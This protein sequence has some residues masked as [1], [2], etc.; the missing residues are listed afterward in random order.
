MCNSNC[1]DGERRATHFYWVMLLVCV[2][3]F[4]NTLGRS[5]FVGYVGPQGTHFTGQCCWFMLG[6]GQLTSPGNVGLCWVLGNTLHRVM[7]LALF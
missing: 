7:L 6:L 5:N 3:P 2:G 4:G 1:S